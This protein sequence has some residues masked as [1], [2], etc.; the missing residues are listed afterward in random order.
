MP[1]LTLTITAKGQVTLRKDLLRHLDVRTGDKID[2]EKLP[3]GRIEMRA[4][5]RTG[6]LSDAY[7]F[8][9]REGGPHLSVEEIDA[10][11]VRGWAGK[12]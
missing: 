3:D 7:G 4:A 6:R 9:K 1:T 8:L 5:P 11:I 10:H 12:R 2:V